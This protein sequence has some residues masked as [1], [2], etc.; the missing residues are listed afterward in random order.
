MVPASSSTSA[1]TPE[2][3]SPNTGKKR[4]INTANRVGTFV[5]HDLFAKATNES[6]LSLYQPNRETS[7]F[8]QETRHR[9]TS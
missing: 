1:A 3:R 5:H 9:E 6:Y 7:A 2:P 4:K 8:Y